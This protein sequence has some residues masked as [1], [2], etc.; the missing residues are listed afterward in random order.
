MKKSKSIWRK[1]LD[2]GSGSPKEVTLCPVSDC[3]LWPFRFGYSIKDKRYFER[4]RNAE[5]QY[6]REYQKFIKSLSEDVKNAPNFPQT[7]KIDN[8][9]QSNFDVIRLNINKD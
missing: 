7:P 5:K 3:S 1:C 8:V 9:L 4:M 6:P 2:C